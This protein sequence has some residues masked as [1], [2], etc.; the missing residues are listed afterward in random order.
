MYG[1]NL[2]MMADYGR[3]IGI[4]AEI[5]AVQSNLLNRELS[6]FAISV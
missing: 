1:V 3:I 6:R 2:V 4:A 5:A